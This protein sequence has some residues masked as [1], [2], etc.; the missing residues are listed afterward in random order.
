MSYFSKNSEN[1]QKGVLGLFGLIIIVAIITIAVNSYQ[2]KKYSKAAFENSQRNTEE[3]FKT[4]S[5]L[6]ELDSSQNK[7]NQDIIIIV[8]DHNIKSKDRKTRL[9]KIENLLQK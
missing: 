8:D 3:I 2:S 5:K 6:V 9:K 1:I 7:T 4:R